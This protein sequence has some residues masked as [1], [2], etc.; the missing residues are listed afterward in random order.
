MGDIWHLNSDQLQ[1][2]SGVFR[3]GNVQGWD[4]EKRLLQYNIMEWLLVHRLK[5]IWQS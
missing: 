2:F 3:D 1:V 5:G 4:L